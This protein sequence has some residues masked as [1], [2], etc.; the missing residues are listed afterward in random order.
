M[1]CM[2][3]SSAFKRAFID[4]VVIGVDFRMYLASFFFNGPMFLVAEKREVV[5]YVDSF[6]LSESRSEFPVLGRSMFM[7]SSECCECWDSLC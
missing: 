7:L 1:F 5:E 3:N 2:N 6:S 4:L